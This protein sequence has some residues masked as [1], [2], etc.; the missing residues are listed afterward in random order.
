[1]LPIDG[2][3]YFLKKLYIRISNSTIFQKKK[4]IYIY[5]YIFLYYITIGGT[6]VSVLFLLIPGR[7]CEKAFFLVL[8]CRY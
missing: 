2:I 7:E 1:M 6:I 3:C 4:N 8:V 5:I